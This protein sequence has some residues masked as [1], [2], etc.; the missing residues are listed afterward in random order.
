MEGLVICELHAC[1]PSQPLLYDS[2][3]L[4]V[5][6]DPISREKTQA[7]VVL[8]IVQRSRCRIWLNFSYFLIQRKSVQLPS[9][10]QAAV[11]NIQLVICLTP[12][13]IKWIFGWKS[14]GSLHTLNEYSVSNPPDLC[15][16]LNKYPV[17][18]LPD[19]CI[20]Q[21]NIQSVIW[22][23]PTYTESIFSQ[24]SAWPTIH[25]P[26]EYSVRNPLHINTFIVCYIDI[27][28]RCLLC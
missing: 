3:H 20:H 14:T 2:Q 25:T 10:L 22:R 16:T 9:S 19:P 12:A 26:N 28:R 27:C 4:W 18:N 21:I 8:D 13:Y 6:I 23:S 7:P 1:H 15:H 5:H 24:Q 11:M 17:S